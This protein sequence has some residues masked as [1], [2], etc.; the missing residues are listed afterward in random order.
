MRLT[1]RMQF[2]ETCCECFCRRRSGRASL[3]N[4]CAKRVLEVGAVAGCVRCFSL[5]DGRAGAI[6]HSQTQ[7]P[8]TAPQ[9]LQN[10]QTTAAP[11][12]QTRHAL[13]RVSSVVRTQCGTHQAAH[14]ET[15]RARGAAASQNKSSA[16]PANLLS[17][18]VH[19]RLG[20]AGATAHSQTQAPHTAPQSFQNCQT[21][22][23]PQT[24]TRHALS[25]VS[26]IPWL[27]SCFMRT[28]SFACDLFDFSLHFISFFI[29][30]LITLLFLMPD[31][32]NF[33]NVVAKYPAY[34]R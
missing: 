23:A 5:G 20:R 26:F 31:I 25:R 34:I 30:S 15:L 19:P 17:V 13:S 29:I 21:T 2:T 18:S 8:H 22:A 1:P 11:Q 12:T 28:V 16:S 33:F 10:C 14:H 3:G 9:S 6:A 7:A 27:S 4:H 24:Q 32:F